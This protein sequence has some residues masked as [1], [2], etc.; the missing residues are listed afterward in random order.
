MHVLTVNVFLIL[1]LAELNFEESVPNL[2]SLLPVSNI[3]LQ[4]SI[5]RRDL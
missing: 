4:G 5:L 2:G 1:T 3:R